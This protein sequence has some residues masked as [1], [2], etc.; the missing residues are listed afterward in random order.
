[1]AGVLKAKEDCLKK[2]RL[3]LGGYLIEL[4]LEMW[5]KTDPSQNC[6]REWRR[7]ARE[8]REAQIERLKSNLAEKSH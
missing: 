2:A 3:T 4:E 5:L 7:V 8:L 6:I 1:M